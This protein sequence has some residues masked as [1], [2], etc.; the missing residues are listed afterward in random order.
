MED[1]KDMGLDGNDQAILAS[2]INPDDAE[3]KRY[4]FGADNERSIL[5]TMIGDQYFLIQCRDLV[6][7]G[8]FVSEHREL[9]C[10][11]LFDHF[12][13]YGR[14]P[15]KQILLAEV[16]A[17]LKR[18]NSKQPMA[19][20]AELHVLED[21]FEPH[22]QNRD[23][24]LDQVEEFAKVQAM[25]EAYLK[26]LDLL[27]KPG[28]EKWAKIWD[29]V[30][31]PQLITR[32]KDEGLDYFGTLR[33]RWARLREQRLNQDKFTV[34]V[35][36]LDMQIN[37]G[38]PC[39]GELYGLVGGSG[40]GK[41]VA[42]GTPI[43]MFDGTI[44]KVE[45]VVVGDLVMGDDSTPR[46]VLGTTHGVGPMYRIVP[47]KGESFVVNGPHVMCLKSAV[48][49][50]EKRP[51]WYGSIYIKPRVR[52]PG[53]WS[54]QEDGVF[55]LS[56]DDY[57]RESTRFKDCMKLYRNAVAFDAK[58]VRIDPYVLGI[59][60]GDG[61]KNGTLLTNMDEAVVAAWCE[62]V[63]GRGL[64]VTVGE[65]G[66]SPA[67][68]YSVFSQANKDHRPGRYGVS[69]NTLMNDLRHYGLVGNKHIPG[70]YKANSEDVRLQVLAGIIDA[71]GSLSSNGYEVASSNDVLADDILFLARSLGFAAYK[72]KRFTKYEKDGKRLPSWR[73]FI[74]G[75][76]DRIPVKIERK[77]APPRSQIKDVLVTGFKVE[78]IG[79]GE[80]FGFQVDG[81]NRFLLGDFTVTHNS[82]MMTQSAVKNVSKGW[83]VL[84]YSLEMKPDKIGQRF[85][86]MFSQH[87]I[88]KL[89]AMSDEELEGPILDQVR[90][91]GDDQRRLIIKQFPAGGADTTTL[92]AYTARLRLGGFNPDVVI[93]DYVGEMKDHP[94]IKTYE[95]RYRTCRDL[96][97]WATEDDFFCLT[98]MQPNRGS[99][100]AQE[101]EKVLQSEH[102]AD[103]FD[104][105]R[106]FDGVWS[107][108]QSKAQREMNLG[109]FA[110]MK[111]RDGESGK[112]FSF[113]RDPH[114]LMFSVIPKEE[115]KRMMGQFQMRKQ[116]ERNEEQRQEAGE[117]GRGRR[118]RPNG[119]GED[120]R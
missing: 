92:R 112:T 38:A 77:K 4:T 29:I 82:L 74:F 61:W 67:K 118:F 24:L 105:I 53:H 98:G 90:R 62:Y 41:C 86:A 96:R 50:L 32:H 11:A 87:D 48:K 14:L 47:K 68:D 36:E 9:I 43:L 117:G 7:P 95:S 69:G 40:T 119:E 102:L 116:K 51:R 73:I 37:G 21:L 39:R 97:G 54:R 72:R 113:Y 26:T 83:K 101:E 75:D 111:I 8:Y 42:P 6:R 25:R 17:R 115:Y 15:T 58:E 71:D 10:Q 44:K 49:S 30:R 99:K 79:E 57:L 81:N 28:S 110:D 70:D 104:Q 114:T 93:V 89:L 91:F 94:G 46:R 19:C 33:E 2:L 107:I 45:D 60:L 103:S 120:D 20:L 52:Y 13:N 100:Q 12:D 64:S 34:G 23:W 31:Q 76:C 78:P 16:Q 22:P 56:V 27:F 66:E 18:S 63:G 65:N 85:D 35:E 108:N 55:E 84:Y 106:V 1:L 59:W 109:I 5:A 88:N 3:E 80:Y